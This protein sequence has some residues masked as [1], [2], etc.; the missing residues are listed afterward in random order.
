MAVDLSLLGDKQKKKYKKIKRNKGRKAANEYFNQVQSGAAPSAQGTAN[1]SA[2]QNRPLTDPNVNINLKNPQQAT[3]VLID[4]QKRLDEQAQL[5]STPNVQ[6]DFGSR[7]V[8]RDPATGQTV[9]K[10]SM[11][12]QEAAMYQENLQSRQN[13]NQAFDMYSNQLQQ[14][15]SFN[16]QLANPQTQQ[17]YQNFFD[18]TY[19]QTMDRFN[20]QVEG[21][22]TRDREALEQTLA[23][24]GVP[25]G[26]EKFNE[27]MSQFQEQANAARE[28]MAN[29]AY[30]QAQQSASTAYNNA[31]AGNQQQFGQQL[32]AYQQPVQNA[33]TF[34]GMAGQFMQPNLGAVQSISPIRTDVGGLGM[35]GLGIVQSAEQEDLN[36][37]MQKYGIDVGAATSKATAGAGSLT[38][39][40]R[41]ALD[42]ANREFQREMYDREQGDRYVTNY[43]P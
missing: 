19:N 18:T 41:Y 35:S 4:E 30:S 6:T 5:T 12:P 28:N 25:R 26:S 10:E 36:R 37:E 38:Y 1:T 14:Q 9:V 32:T 29:S 16:P 17:S 15:G 31:L 39:D 21:D 40:Q 27:A 33:A 23:M 2:T 20:R 24:Q 7:A 3:N 8:E 11:S 22:I 42:Q 34:M 43:N 13:I